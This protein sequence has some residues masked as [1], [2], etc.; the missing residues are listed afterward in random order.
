MPAY[1]GD[2]DT[3]DVRADKI[4]DELRS[5]VDKDTID[6]QYGVAS[7]WS[8]GLISLDDLERVRARF[9]RMQETVK[10]LGY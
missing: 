8:L 9:L 6:G 7:N 1:I 2:D 3:A 4:L 5:F 10:K